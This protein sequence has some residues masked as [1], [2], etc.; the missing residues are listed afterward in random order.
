MAT[1][2][3]DDSASTYMYIEVASG[4]APALGRSARIFG[5]WNTVRQC[6]PTPS[7]WLLALKMSRDGDSDF[8]GEDVVQIG[9]AERPVSWKS[10]E[11]EFFPCKMGGLPSWLDNVRTPSLSC[12]RCGGT[13]SFAL[14]VR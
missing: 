7:D 3:F 5:N 2:H 11:R 9:Y 10:L 1:L 14:Q 13:L 8:S 4:F 12:K 6:L